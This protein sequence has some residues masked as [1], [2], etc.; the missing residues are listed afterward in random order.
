MWGIITKLLTLIIRYIQPFTV[1]AFILCGF[2]YLILRN[3]SV[4]FTNLALAL[5]N[6]MVFYGEAIFK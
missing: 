4:G 5:A 2:C 1:F 6:F 3:W